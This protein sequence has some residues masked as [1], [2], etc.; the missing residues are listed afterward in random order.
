MSRLELTRRE[1]VALVLI[2]PSYP[3][4]KRHRCLLTDLAAERHLPWID[5]EDVLA[6]VAVAERLSKI[7]YFL[8]GDSFH[9]NPVGHARMAQAIGDYLMAHGLLDPD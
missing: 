5:M 6:D 9:P 8:P 1:G 2:H 7:D 3:V 4:S